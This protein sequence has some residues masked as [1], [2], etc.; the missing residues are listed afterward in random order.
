[1]TRAKTIPTPADVIAAIAADPDCVTATW[2]QGEPIK[3]RVMAVVLPTGEGVRL[4]IC[5]SVRLQTLGFAPPIW[6]E[7]D[8]D[9]SLYPVS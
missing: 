5:E 1:M 9:A 8:A 4:V 3:Y 7:W 6:I 2:D